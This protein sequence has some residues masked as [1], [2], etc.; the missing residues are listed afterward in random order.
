MCRKSGSSRVLRRMAV[1]RKLIE[2]LDLSS[3]IGK[4]YRQRKVTVGIVVVDAEVGGDGESRVFRIAAVKGF[5]RAMPPRRRLVMS[6]EYVP[7][8]ATSFGRE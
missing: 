7:P 3:E 2:A 8:K 6:W 5:L 4:Y 1:G